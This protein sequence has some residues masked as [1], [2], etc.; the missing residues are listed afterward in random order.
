MA[1]QARSRVQHATAA[2]GRTATTTGDEVGAAALG[3]S[4]AE[5]VKRLRRDRHLSL[6]QLSAQ[7][8]VSR[9]ALSQIEGARTNPTLAVLWKIAVGLN[10]PFQTLL[11]TDD[12]ASTRV[13][14]AG[15]AAPLR[16]ADGRIE[17]RLLSPAGANGNVDVYEL[18]FQP[19]GVLTS[20]AHASGTTETLIVLTG[21]LRL[22]VAE[23]THDLL[24]G[25]TIFFQADATHVYEN[26]ST[27]ETRCLDIVVYP[28]R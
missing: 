8:G 15:D 26:R 10:V 12:G 9:A 18:R 23:E 17:S 7:S 20:E 27:H 2:R 25:D 16:S 19:K 21:G 13:L 3:R 4:V 28:Q 6:D 24:P 1:K 14:R 11:G 22:S 5:A